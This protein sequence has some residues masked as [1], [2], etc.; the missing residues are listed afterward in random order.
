[1]TMRST[2]RRTGESTWSVPSVDEFGS[3]ERQYWPPTVHREAPTDSSSRH[4]AADRFLRPVGSNRRPVARTRRTG[5]G[6]RVR[7]VDGGSTGSSFNKGQVQPCWAAG[8]IR[9][10]YSTTVTANTSTAYSSVNSSCGGPTTSGHGSRR[11][12]IARCASRGRR[13]RLLLRWFGLRARQTTSDSIATR[14]SRG[15]S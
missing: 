10:T 12:V 8:L 13:S 5:D 9:P 15:G 4:C 1:M 6:G 2:R 3:G 7:P 11:R 14:L